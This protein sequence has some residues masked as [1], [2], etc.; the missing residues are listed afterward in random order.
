MIEFIKGPYTS[1]IAGV[2][3]KETAWKITSDKEGLN[4]LDITPLS[5]DTVDR[6]YSNILIPKGEEVYIWYQMKLTNDEIKDWVGPTPYQSRDSN[7]SND[8][9]PLLRIETPYS[10]VD[11]DSLYSGANMIKVESSVFRGDPIDGILSSTWVV[12]NPKGEIILFRPRDIARVNE[13][14]LNRSSLG[15][16]TYDY[17]DIYLKHHS[18]NG[19]TSDFGVNRVRLDVYPFKFSGGNVV[20]STK[21]Y[22]FMII[23]YDSNNPNISSIRV[24]ESNTGL[25]VYSFTDMSDLVFTIPA[26]TL[27]SDTEYRIECFTLNPDGLYPLKLNA[28]IKTISLPSSVIYDDTVVYDLNSL[29][30]KG[31]A[32]TSG[33]TETALI[34]GKAYVITD[35]NSI[36]RYTVNKL[37]ETFDITNMNISDDLIPYINNDSKLILLKSGEIILISRISTLV[38]IVFLV[39]KNN[40]IQ[41]NKTKNITSYPCRDT[42]QNIKNCTTI[43]LD[44]MYIY[45]NIIDDTS[46]GFVMFDI[47]KRVLTRLVTREGL[48]PITYNP[49]TILIIANG[50]DTIFSIGGNS[51]DDLY[52]EY[53]IKNKQW[54][55]RGILDREL[56]ES[57]KPDAILLQN[58]TILFT[59][60][61]PADLYVVS[62]NN[63]GVLV[64]VPAATSLTKYNISFI[65]DVGT[66][67]MLNHEESK[68]FTVKSHRL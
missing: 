40:N 8:L 20:D 25:V 16:G 43:T 32:S 30:P 11:K 27:S 21:D 26:Y 53:N 7:I 42:F 9:K 31:F 48:S 65:D 29:A 38:N 55:P 60:N 52:Y 17:I 66:L 64:T 68:L 37:T 10:I 57:V 67:Y 33:K 41:M 63:L 58:R 4:I 54:I 39:E 19:S 35:S 56:V 14:E 49:S 18:A 46:V 28:M 22:E 59:N 36:V 50:L 34:D 5:A 47:V 13:I 61:D 62:I 1:P 12:K 3:N 2:Y 15:L 24:V 44:G 51:N 6:Y 23:P 45:L